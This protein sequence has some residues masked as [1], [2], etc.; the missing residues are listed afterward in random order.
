MGALS[1]DRNDRVDVAESGKLDRVGSDRRASAVDDE[2][3]RC[4]GGFAF[5]SWRPGKLEPE[6]MVQRYHCRETR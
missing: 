5:G 2:R 4:V 3:R 6:M 1:G